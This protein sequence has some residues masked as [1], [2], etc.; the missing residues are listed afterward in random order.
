MP[1]NCAVCIGN[2]DGVHLGHQAL[3][4]AARRSVGPSG[5]V[6][7]VTFDPMPAEA[8]GGPFRRRLSRM[9]ERQHL[10]S[11]HGADEV[12]VEPCTKRLLAQQPEEFIHGLRAKLNFDVIVEG[13]DFRFGHKR[14]GSVET[15]RELGP[16]HS[17]TVEVVPDLLVRLE[18]ASE[19]PARSTATRWLLE[20][21]RVVDARRMLGRAPLLDGR[22]MPGDQRGRTLG[23]P[24]ANLEVG[25]LLLPA[26]GV[27]S[28]IA[29]LPDG[30]RRRAAV[31]VGTKPTFGDS[32]RTVE[33]HI[34]EW[35]APLNEYGWPLR[36][37]LG[38]WI[39]SQQVCSGIAELVELIRRDC[40]RVRESA[41]A[42]AA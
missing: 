18:D 3:L 17:F 11:E 42:F 39:R 1:S 32:P 8:L 19:V 13:P 15:L 20:Q 12:V 14:T 22:V 33:A 21:G 40:A 35:S 23:F 10:L 9:G 25:P 37:H 27:Y 6:V 4:A 5:R 31:S 28:A 30:S 34:L 24:T 36:L 29:E 41:E 16:R 7:A 26:D 38:R 2:F